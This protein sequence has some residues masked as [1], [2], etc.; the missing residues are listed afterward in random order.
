MIT[1]TPPLLAKSGSRT[2]ARAL[3]YIDKLSD[4]DGYAVSLKVTERTEHL[5]ILLHEACTAHDAPPKYIGD[6]YR[7]YS[8][9]EI[10]QIATNLAMA[11]RIGKMQGCRFEEPVDMEQYRLLFNTGK[12]MLA[13]HDVPFQEVQPITVE[14]NYEVHADDPEVLKLQ[15]GVQL[16]LPMYEQETVT[17]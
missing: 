11:G 3:A 15:P 13:Y 8:E 5:I 10:K 2:V 1:N 4:R 12:A 6:N 14:I 7:A 16:T 9:E 17:T